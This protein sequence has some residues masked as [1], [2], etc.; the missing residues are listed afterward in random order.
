MSGASAAT[1]AVEEGAGTL[2]VT[3]TRSGLTNGPVTASYITTA[4][5]ATAGADYTHATGSVTFADGDQAPKTFSVAMVN[6]SLQES[7]ESF[8]VRLS[9]TDGSAALGAPFEAPVT[10][11]DND[12]RHRHPRQRQ[13]RRLA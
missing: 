3:V 10:I 2:T 9:I 6:D 1:Y 8:G 7:A 12:L 4:S 5:S 11:T 13:H